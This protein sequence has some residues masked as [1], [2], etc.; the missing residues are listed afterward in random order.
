[1]SP[2]DELADVGGKPVQ[3]LRG[4]EG[5]GEGVDGRGWPGDVGWAILPKGTGHAIPPETKRVKTPTCNLQL[6]GPQGATLAARRGKHHSYRPVPDQH[7]LPGDTPRA[8]QLVSGKELPRGGGSGM[9]PF[10]SSVKPQQKTLSSVCYP[11][12]TCALAA[13]PLQSI[14]E[15]TG[16]HT[17]A[18]KT[19]GPNGLRQLVTG[20]I[21]DQ[22]IRV[23]HLKEEIRLD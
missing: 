17:S 15:Q 10:A 3:P 2:G 6:T 18:L 4:G 16:Y 13:T 19:G 21:M 7:Y 12:D 11:L 1:M 5:E 23:T 9:G 22:V 20:A 14:P 8:I